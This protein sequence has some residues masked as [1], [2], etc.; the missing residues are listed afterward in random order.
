MEG[1]HAPLLI[2]QRS[3]Y[4]PYALAV[5]VELPEDPLLKFTVPG[6]LTLLH[7]PLPTVGVFPPSALEIKPQA[8]RV[9]EL[10]LAVVGVW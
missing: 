5:A 7:A 8:E 1:A 6:P 4:V 3:T 9:L 10:T 2:V